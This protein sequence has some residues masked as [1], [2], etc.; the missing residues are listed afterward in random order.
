MSLGWKVLI[1]F[2]LVWILVLSVFRG[3]QGSGWARLVVVAFVVVIVLLAVLVWGWF[4]D[5]K[6]EELEE[7][8]APPPPFDAFAGGYP[9]PP[10]LG[11]RVPMFGDSY[12]LEPN[13]LAYPPVAAER[14]VG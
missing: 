8:A 14:G 1:P 3:G 2:N 9:V 6:T 7:N 13:D 5:R 4:A 11:D 10:P 12:G